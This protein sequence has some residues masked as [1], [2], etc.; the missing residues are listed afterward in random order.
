MKL[1]DIN[2]T[3]IAAHFV[4]FFYGYIGLFMLLSYYCCTLHFS[5]IIHDV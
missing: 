4:R 2:S 3:N 1:A 5:Q